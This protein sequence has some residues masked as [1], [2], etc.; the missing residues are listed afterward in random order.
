M[1]LRVLNYYLTV[2][3][4]GSITKAAE[5]LHVSQPNLSRQLKQLEEEL[6]TIL[7]FRGTKKITLT[8]DGILFQQ[9]ANEII[10]LV[11]KTTNEFTQQKESLAGTISIGC[12]E[13]VASRMLSK[14]L[15]DFSERYPLVR[16]DLYSAD[17]DDIR[18]K[19][20]K[21]LIDVG[22]LLE[23]IETSKYNYIRLPYLEK[24]GVVMRRDDPLAL[25]ETIGLEEV[26]RLPLI[27][28]RRMIV[29]NEISNWFGTTEEELQIVATHNLLTNASLLVEEKLGYAICVE[30]AHE[31]RGSRNTCFIP[32]APIRTT[33]HVFAWR[34]SQIF[35]SATELFIQFIRDNKKA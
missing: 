15:R 4:E 5:V 30:G 26:S 19:L 3:R 13:S 29:K 20:D 18:E 17:G 34:K 9:R 1:E 27:P 33:G 10:S 32:F 28:P 11:S 8:N 16:Y 2:A 12:V 25:R 31:I 24:W 6:G 22:I 21:G 23:P 7:F 14:V 35:N